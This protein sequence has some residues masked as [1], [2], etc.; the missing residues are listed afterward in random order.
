MGRL[1]R[2]TV[3]ASFGGKYLSNN[4]WSQEALQQVTNVGQIRM[5]ARPSAASGRPCQCCR[6]FLSPTRQSHFSSTATAPRL[7]HLGAASFAHRHWSRRAEPRV[8][9]CLIFHPATTGNHH[10]RGSTGSRPGTNNLCPQN[11]WVSVGARLHVV[12]GAYVVVQTPEA[13]HGPG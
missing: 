3:F 7:L 13:W 10:R 9:C 12:V 11:H 6:Q 4:A 8:G 2:P 5:A 1:G